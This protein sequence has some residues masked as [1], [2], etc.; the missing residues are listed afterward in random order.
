MANM[1]DYLED[2]MIKYW[3][4]ND[5]TAAA[6]PATVYVALYT[7]IPTDAS[8]SGTEVTGGSYARVAVTNNATNWPGPTTNNGTVTNG[9][10]ITFPAPTGNWGTVVGVAIYDAATAG[11]QLFWGAL[12]TNKTIPSGDPAPVFAIGAFSIQFDN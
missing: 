6:K 11:N 4:Q 1:S 3:L 10:T 5:G 7:V 2:Q 8:T 9:A 12:T